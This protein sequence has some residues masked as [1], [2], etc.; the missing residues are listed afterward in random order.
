M[1]PQEKNK[2]NRIVTEEDKNRIRKNWESVGFLS[3]LTLSTNK[4]TEDMF[5]AHTG[6]L[7]NENQEDSSIPKY[8]HGIKICPP[9]KIKNDKN[10]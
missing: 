10:I 5:S 1:L 2:F 7:L 9:L 8:I 3:G 4:E 6:Y